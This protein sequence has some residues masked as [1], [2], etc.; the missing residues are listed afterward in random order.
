[1]GGFEQETG[2]GASGRVAV[3]SNL[4]EGVEVGVLED[5][6]VTVVACRD[7][8]EAVVFGVIAQCKTVAEADAVVYI[9]V[10]KGIVT[11]AL[12]KDFVCVACVAAVVASVLCI[13]VLKYVVVGVYE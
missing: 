12:E 11:G 5:D 2:Q 1:M 4:V 9:D 3:C 7:R 13:D 6:A 10:L 8:G